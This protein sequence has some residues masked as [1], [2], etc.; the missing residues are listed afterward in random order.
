MLSSPVR[1][2]VRAHLHRIDG[3]RY[4]QFR[5]VCPAA[6]LILNS[7]PTRLLSSSFAVVRIISDCVSLPGS[8]QIFVCF[9]PR[10]RTP[11]CPS[12]VPSPYLMEGVCVTLT[13]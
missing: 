5:L 6:R 4:V 9:R 8:Y 2:L 7:G 13:V 11:Q 10:K 12:S 1:T 3:Q